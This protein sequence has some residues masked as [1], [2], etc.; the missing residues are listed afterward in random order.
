M[1]RSEELRQRHHGLWEAVVTHPFVLE[2]GEGTLPQEKFQRYF[3]QDYLFVKELASLLAL[4]VAKAPD[5]HSARKLSEFL[6]LLLG[7]EEALFR[8]AFREMGMT[9]AE[10]KAL[11][12]LPTC[13]SFTSF[14]LKTAYQGTFADIMA[15]LYCVEGTY[16]DWAQ[17]LARAG[18]RPGVQAYQEWISIHAGPELEGFVRWVKEALDGLGTT[19]D[20]RLDHVFSHCLRLE[21]LFWEMAYRG[22]EWPG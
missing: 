7:G 17:R 18:K 3:E 2:M 9:E 16:L 8:H 22:E 4:G 19:E 21:Y 15:S 6:G 14:L 1:S 11:Q 10:V 5:F 20:E 12:P 13:L